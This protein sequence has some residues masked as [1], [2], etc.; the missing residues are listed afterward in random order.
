[1]RRTPVLGRLAVCVA[2]PSGRV[3][4]TLTRLGLRLELLSSLVIAL[5]IISRMR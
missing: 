5:A 3:A 4:L 2:D 1:M